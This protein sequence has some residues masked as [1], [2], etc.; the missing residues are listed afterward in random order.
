[1]KVKIKEKKEIAKGALEVTFDFTGQDLKY[2]AGQ[3]C[4]ITLINPPYTD[5]RGNSRFL[6]FTSSPSQ[7]DSFSIVTRTG[8]SGFKK[9]LGELPI[10]T[11]VEM[12]G[13][14]GRINLPADKTQPVVFVAGGIGIAPVMG[15][16]RYCHEN[17]WEYSV[18]LVYS[19]KDRASAIFFDELERYSK[20]NNKFRFIPTMTDDP[21][22]TGEKRKINA[23]FIKTYFPEPGN[24]VYFVTGT[25][26]FVPSVFK[27]IKEAGVPILNLRMEIFTG[28]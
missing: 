15:I 28:Y 16:I 26:K 2:K 18:T 4:S 12:G 9:S 7:K 13:I 22:W 8:T 17:S 21:S 25:P 3:F 1:M 19:N 27:E 6:G 23:E 14:D 24:N 11:E 5:A 20:E 10:G